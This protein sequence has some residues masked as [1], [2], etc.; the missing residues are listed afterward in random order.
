MSTEEHLQDEGL[1]ALDSTDWI[2]TKIGGLNA[3]DFRGNFERIDR[4]RISGKKQVVVISVLRTGDFNTTTHLN[5]LA[6]ILMR[7]GEGYAER[8]GLAIQEIEQKLRGII[9]ENVE[10]EWQPSLFRILET[11][12]G[13][14][15]HYVEMTEIAKFPTQGKDFLIQFDGEVFSISGWGEDLVEALYK[16]YFAEKGKIA[17]EISIDRQE[18][19]R[20]P[21]VL[22]ERYHDAVAAILN[23]DLL[24]TGGYEA[25]LARTR[26]YSDPKAALLTESLAHHGARAVLAV[27]KQQPILSADPSILPNSA[28]PIRV[29]SSKFAAEVF[30]VLGAEAGA[31]HPLV[32]PI[33]NGSNAKIVVFNPARPELGTTCIYANAVMPPTT[34]I[35]RKLVP[36]IR[37]YGPM[38]DEKG[39][40]E[41]VMRALS[42]F[43]L[44][45]IYTAENEV[46]VTLSAN[47]EVEDIQKIGKGYTH[48]IQ[49]RS[50]V[51]CVSTDDE[52]ARGITVLRDHDIKVESS[53]FVA[54]VGNDPHV[55]VSSYVVEP[56]VS[57]AAVT[58]LHNTFVTKYAA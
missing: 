49:N 11:F 38:S 45:Q 34:L 7:K 32:L 48:T 5:G 19:Y 22:R 20:T 15:S 14:L 23:E 10:G 37:V 21:E 55:N 28:V 1:E 24:I 35:S 42:E 26:S 46:R 57:T 33:L 56:E 31:L 58:H 47:G 16:A 40:A 29:M 12:V 52:I 30:G 3:C 25:E 2:V 54:E 18:I 36:T 27:E 41:E 17:A 13:Q 6:Q 4:N 53:S 43:N 8:A 44:D 51:M 9:Q 50:V 39:I